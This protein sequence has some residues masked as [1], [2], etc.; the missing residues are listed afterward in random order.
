MSIATKAL[1]A[2]LAPSMKARGFTFRK[3]HEAFVSKQDVGF[4]E[5]SLISFHRGGQQTIRPGLGVRHDRVEDVVNQLG[6]IYGDENRRNTTTVYRGLGLFPFRAGGV[7][8]LHIRTDQLERDVEA[9]AA[10]IDDMFAQDGLPFLQR[11]SSLRECS[12]DLNEPLDAVAHPLANH[13]GQRAYRG[14]V[15]AALCE[16]AKVSSLVA[17]YADLA[18]AGRLRDVGI[19]Y[20]VGAGLGE[21]K[22]FISRLETVAERALALS[23]AMDA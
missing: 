4:V 16:P 18:Q 5:L 13:P 14:V 3:A 6:H 10:R 9:A 17:A 7:S 1:V 21:E 2:R 19:V 20:D 22:A 11:Y 23:A 15:A 12:S 8:T